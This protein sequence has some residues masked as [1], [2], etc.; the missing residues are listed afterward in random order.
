[1]QLLQINTLRKPRF[2]VSITKITIKGDWEIGVNYELPSEDTERKVV[3]FWCDERPRNEFIKA[4]EE[5]KPNLSTICGLEG[6]IWETG[7]ISSISFKEHEQG[8]IVGIALR[9]A[10]EQAV[11]TAG[12][13]SLYPTG[14]FL[15]KIGNLIAEVE[16]YIDGV[17]QVEQM[18]IDDFLP[19]KDA[20]I[21]TG[22]KPVVVSNENLEEVAGF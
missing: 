20:V 6:K 9:T 21:G 17:R 7:R 11:V 14:E 4:F 8:T 22:F 5:L 2:N 12:V 16:D 10:S 19:P 13:E 3:R 18:T 1:M 15:E